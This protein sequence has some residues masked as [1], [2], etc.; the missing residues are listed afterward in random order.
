MD[1]LSEKIVDNLD[2]LEQKIVNTGT[3]YDSCYE[4]GTINDPSIEFVVFSGG[5]VSGIAFAG[6]VKELEIFKIRENVKYWAGSSIGSVCAM[7]VVLGMSA[8]ALID[9]LLHTNMKTFIEESGF[10]NSKISIF[11]K[12]RNFRD[13][14]F[15]FGLLNGAKFNNWIRCQ[16]SN[17][18]YSPDITFSEVYEKTGKHLIITVTS[19]NTYETLYLSRSSYP[20][21]KVSEAIRGSVLIPFLFQPIS[22]E[23]PLMGN[24]SR[25][26]MDGGVLDNL[27]INA[28]D[29][30]SKTGEVLAFNRK[31]IGFKVMSNGKLTPDYTN[32][33]CLLQ[34]S[35]T[36]IDSLHN[37]IHSSQCNQPYFWD[38]IVPIDTYGINTFT[39][40]IDDETMEKIL[41]SG[42]EH[43]RKFLTK[44][45]EMIRI[46]GPLPKNLFIPNHRLRYHGI[47]FLSDE[48]IE[49]T[50]IYQTNPEN[51]SSNII[52]MFD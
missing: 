45:N 16:I 23:D 27:P 12:I 9:E 31:A 3:L 19:I 4:I 39:F 47:E 14:F 8:D 18:G 40:D 25:L 37:Q 5:G 13:L 28:C 11:Q 1:L 29:I 38:R 51:F 42:R 36:F 17:L 41:E 26:L 30:T 44:R 21:M 50:A 35:L 6:V 43:T 7:L 52:P 48:L 34:Y 32:I 46:K 15:K 33:D 22:M 20:D 49:N 24:K 10:F 2:E